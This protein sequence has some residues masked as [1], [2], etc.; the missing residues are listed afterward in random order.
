MKNFAKLWKWENKVVLLLITV[1]ILGIA[2]NFAFY[3]YRVQ[4]KTN[5]FEIFETWAQ[6]KLNKRYKV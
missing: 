3:E 1:I 2:A 4:K 5:D 6:N